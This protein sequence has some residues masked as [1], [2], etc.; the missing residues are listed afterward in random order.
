MSE[1]ITKFRLQDVAEI[2]VGSVL[3]AFPIAVTEEVWVISEKLPLGRTLLISLVSVSF[4]AW[5]GYYMFYKNAL[6]VHRG[7]FILRIITVYVITLIVAALILFAIDQFPLLTEPRV[8]IK[9]MI[10]VA[11]PASFSATVVDSLH[12][13]AGNR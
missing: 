1:E 4:I 7:E 10:I 3:L 12:S 5:F 6:S 2:I 11:L 9:R 8:A 13:S